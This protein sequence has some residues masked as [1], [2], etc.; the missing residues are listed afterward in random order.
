MKFLEAWSLVEKRLQNA[1]VSRLGVATVT[2]LGVAT[3]TRL[4]VAAMGVSLALL[5][6]VT[7][8]LPRFERER[9]LEALIEAEVLKLRGATQSLNALNARLGKASEARLSA[10][11]FKASADLRDRLVGVQAEFGRIEALLGLAAQTPDY[12]L[13]A[14]MIDNAKDA[15]SKALNASASLSRS[16]A[17]TPLSP[18]PQTPPEPAPRARGGPS[19]GAR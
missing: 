1:T 14:A 15:S 8:L 12:H 17:G 5:V 16:V 9:A 11:A 3:M 7:Y 18:P 4:G 10:T 13:R 2:R 6:T 19:R